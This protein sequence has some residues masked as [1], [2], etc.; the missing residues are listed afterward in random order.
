MSKNVFKITLSNEA[1]DKLVAEHCR[2]VQARE[3]RFTKSSII[4]DLIISKL[5]VR[6]E[7][8]VDDEKNN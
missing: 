8:T 7:S 6:K 2:R 1:F 5:Q 3:K 4:E